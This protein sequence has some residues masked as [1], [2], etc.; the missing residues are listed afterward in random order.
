MLC[1]KTGVLCFFFFYNNIG[2]GNDL[3]LALLLKGEEF[4]YGSLEIRELWGGDLG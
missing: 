4:I 2:R 1:E 3:N